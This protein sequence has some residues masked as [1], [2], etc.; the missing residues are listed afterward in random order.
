M[1]RTVRTDKPMPR[2]HALNL[3]HATQSDSALF[4]ALPCGANN[5]QDLVRQENYSLGNLASALLGVEYNPLDYDNVPAYFG[6]LDQVGAPSTRIRVRV[7]PLLT[8][9]IPLLS[10]HS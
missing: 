1:S 9:T 2:Y 10:P 4:H 5:R 8:V 3:L 7:P 6:T